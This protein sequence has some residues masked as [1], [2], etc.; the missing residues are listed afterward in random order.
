MEWDPLGN[1]QLN[2][3]CTDLQ[4]GH[5]QSGPLDAQQLYLRFIPCL[6]LTLLLDRLILDENTQL[7]FTPHTTKA[8]EGNLWPI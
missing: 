1:I 3:P 2:N 5:I 7:K 8:S 4:W 6:N